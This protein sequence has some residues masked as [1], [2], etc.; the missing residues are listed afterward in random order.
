MNNIYKYLKYKRKYLDIQEGGKNLSKHM[1]TEHLREPWFSLISLGLKTIDGRKNKGIFKKMK[2]GEIIKWINNDFNNRSI[3]TKITRITEYDTFKKML[4]T[5][6][7]NN[8]LPS[9]YDIETGLSIYYK[10]YTKEDEI[11]YGVLAIELKL[12]N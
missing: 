10:Y 3:L 8:V 6:G 7:L 5:E 9:I 1:Y 11:E 12:I 2:V 4:E